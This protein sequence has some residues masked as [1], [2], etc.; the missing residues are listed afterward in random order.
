MGNLYYYDIC[1]IMVIAVLMH[2]VYT[3]RNIEART[4][5]VLLGMMTVT[6]LSAIADLVAAI[7]ENGGATG[8]A[9]ISLAYAANYLYFVAHPLIFPM[10]VLY[11]YA[12]FDL[13]NV[14]RKQMFSRIVWWALILGD[15][16]I[17]A[18]NPF[19]HGLFYNM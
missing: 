2:I 5:H 4:N 13:W 9:G 8:N 14:F 10:Y 6:I 7:V 19:A 1:A 15:L 16:L 12:S 11:I 17:L 3:R 18:I